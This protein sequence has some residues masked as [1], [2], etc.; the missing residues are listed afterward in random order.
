MLYLRHKNIQHTSAI[1]NWR[2]GDSRTF[3][4]TMPIANDIDP[5]RMGPVLVAYRH[6]PTA[7]LNT[8]FR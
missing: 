6:W 1:P 5:V 4:L 7:E 8:H 3:G 2:L